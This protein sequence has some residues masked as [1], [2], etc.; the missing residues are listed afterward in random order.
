[1]D[2]VEIDKSFIHGHHAHD[3]IVQQMKFDV[4]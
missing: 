2:F 1:L 4:D 3:I